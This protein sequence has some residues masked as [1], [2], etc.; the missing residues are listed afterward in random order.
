[1]YTLDAL[2][3]W[4]RK[5]AKYLADDKALPHSP[6]LLGTRLIERYRPFGVVGVIGPWNYPLVN[7]FGD[8]IPALMAGNTVVLKPSSLTPLTSL[9]IAEGLRESGLPDDVFL[10]ATGSGDTGSALVDFADFMHFTGSTEV[11]RK[12]MARAAETLTP[13]TL[14]LGGKDPMIVCADADLERAANSALYYSMQNSGQ[15]CISVERVY[16]EE[17]VYEDFVSRVAAKARELRQGVP[18]GPGSVEVGAVT[19]PEQAELIE[20]HVRDAVEK[21]ARVLV[22]GA[23]K[24]VG[25]GTFFQP[26]VL[27]DVDHSMEIMTEETFGPTL[28]IMR[29]RDSEEA[30]RLANDS[31]YGLDS[32]VFTSDL[33]KGERLARRVQAGAACVNDCFINYLA[34]EVPFGGMK[35]SGIGG[36]HGPKGIQKYCRTQQIMVKRFA[37]KKE[38]HF[39]PYRKWVTK[40]LGRT[41]G[42]LYGRGR[43][44]R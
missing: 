41:L 35:E 27:R 22:G 36:R 6:F 15:A 5:A 17:P 33:E 13:V 7:N 20:R 1:L 34:L 31:R 23:R 37:P 2:G 32:S 12:V 3:F 38:I 24:D 16:V 10:V 29:V 40:A 18:R 19:H 21:G 25:D 9:L 14:E 44:G 4:A 43:W 11:G 42:L 26:T 8:A 28:P 30:I 39:F